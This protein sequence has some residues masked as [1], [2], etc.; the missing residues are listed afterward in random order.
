MLRRRFIAEPIAGRN[1]P[2]GSIQNASNETW[3][4]N[5]GAGSSTTFGF[6]ATSNS[7]NSVPAKSR[8]QA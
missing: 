1:A 5:L 7:A 8:A 2:S 4:G 6:I 3:N